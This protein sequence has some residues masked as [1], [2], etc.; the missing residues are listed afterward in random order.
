M[1]EVE[2][3]KSL[4][5]ILIDAIYWL[6]HVR[7]HMNLGRLVYAANGDSWAVTESSEVSSDL[8]KAIMGVCSC[9]T[10]FVAQLYIKAKQDFQ[11][12]LCLLLSYVN[13]VVI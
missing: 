12:G 1:V 8:M 9:H 2:K 3:V 6:F 11:A 5:F 10:S 4:H 13:E 7:P